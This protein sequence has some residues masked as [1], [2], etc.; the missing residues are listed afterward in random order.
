MDAKTLYYH[1]RYWRKSSRSGRLATWAVILI[2]VSKLFAVWE[3]YGP[4]RGIVLDASTG[5]PLEDAVVLATYNRESGTIADRGTD[6][7]V[8][9]AEA[10]TDS[11]GRYFIPPK[12]V[13]TWPALQLP[14]LIFFW[15]SGGADILIRV[16][17]TLEAVR[18]R[19]S[20]STYRCHCLYC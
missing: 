13:V 1:F 15:L 5:K 11:D 2:I 14:P 4:Y 17:T 3:F 18:G 6:K 12:L 8:G 9:V 7:V 19:I 16:M 10:V 20:A